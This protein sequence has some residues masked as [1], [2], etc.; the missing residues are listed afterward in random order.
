[1]FKHIALF[2][3]R[4]GFR[5]LS[6]YIY[7]ALFF[8]LGYLIFMVA[9]GVFPGVDM[10]LG[11]GGKLY[12]NSHFMLFV[13]VSSTSYYGL[14]V[15]AAVMGNAA[16]RDFRHN[17]YPL[18][19]TAPITKLQYLGG[20]FLAA[21]VIL[22]FIFSSIGIACLAAGLTAD[23]DERLI[24]PYHFFAYLA[25][26]LFAVIP[27][28]LFI[29]AIFFA[30][31]ALTRNMLPVYVSAVMLFVGYLIAAVL[32][33][34]LDSKYVAGLI[35][36]FGN[37]A[38][39]H[40]I[41]YW[42]VAEKNSLAIPMTGLM[43]V[44][45]LIWTSLGLVVLGVTCWVFRMQQGGEDRRRLRESAVGV[46]VARQVA[47]PVATVR[48]SSQASFLP[49]LIWLE[50]YRIVA[51]VPFLLIVLC[52]IGFVIVSSVSMQAIFGTSI[53]AGGV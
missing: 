44:N 47:L 27:N 16:H 18:I 1:M 40:V 42:T 25:P 33:T 20:R 31:A 14:L 34:Q 49:K 39:E 4:S 53:F 51:S 12:A 38:L 46:A 32:S 23:V 17:T 52:G 13:L 29:G 8:A 3:I 36:P 11:A 45:R 26:Y 41:Q 37:F 30:M 28:T 50:F 5:R 24:G 48:V 43:L 35:D 2:E 21:N 6:T 10:G 15:V 22:L 7:F 9:A 19:F